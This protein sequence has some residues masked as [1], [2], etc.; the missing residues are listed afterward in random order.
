MKNDKKYVLFIVIFQDFIRVWLNVSSWELRRRQ[1]K[2]KQET[3]KVCTECQFAERTLSCTETMLKTAG[4]TQ[5]KPGWIG[6]GGFWDREISTNSKLFA[7]HWHT[8]NVKWFVTQETQ[9]NLPLKIRGNR[10]QTPNYII[11][12]M[13]RPTEAY[14]RGYKKDVLWDHHCLT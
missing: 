12:I 11:I 1:H 13:Q 4:K 8:P 2:M 9:V 7:E 3:P 6:Q 14:Y 10:K 5:G